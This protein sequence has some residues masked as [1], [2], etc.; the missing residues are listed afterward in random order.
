MRVKEQSSGYKFYTHIKIL[1]PFEL[2]QSI[3]S[4]LLKYLELDK[5]CP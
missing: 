2:K 1:E 4:Q 3:N 5:M